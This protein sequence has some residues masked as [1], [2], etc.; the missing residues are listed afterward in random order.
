MKF[1]IL[2]AIFA[3]VS[4]I[5]ISQELNKEREQKIICENKFNYKVK[6]GKKFCA[7]KV[8]EG[9]LTDVN[10]TLPEQYLSIFGDN[11]PRE[12]LVTRDA[13]RDWICGDIEA[14]WP[15]NLKGTVDE[16]TLQCSHATAEYKKC[17]MAEDVKMIDEEVCKKK[18][19]HASHLAK[20]FFGCLKTHVDVTR[21]CWKEKINQELNDENLENWMC[22][23]QD[24]ITKMYQ[25]IFCGT[26]P[27][28][29]TEIVKCI[30]TAY[31]AM[32]L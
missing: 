14:R 24:N 29:R 5:V 28:K 26:S 21:D 7:A 8:L 17:L 2:L 31:A 22:I 10:S 11:V 27:S 19:K 4:S 6:W 23:S 30:D 32:E 9:D 3:S 16:S 12:S 13:Y 20:G 18:S 15:E 1:L 25:S